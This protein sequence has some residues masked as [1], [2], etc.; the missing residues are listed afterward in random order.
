MYFFVTKIDQLAADFE[1]LR[2]KEVDLLK[3][4]FQLATGSQALC[5]AKQPLTRPSTGTCIQ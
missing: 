2:L 5:P 4:S 1:S 3:I